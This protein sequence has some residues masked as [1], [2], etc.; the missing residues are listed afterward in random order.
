MTEDSSVTAR[1]PD[2]WHIDKRVSVGHLITTITV[3]VAAIVWALR[4]EG[5]LDVT[6]VNVQN[7]TTAIRQARD[8]RAVQYGEIIRRLER[9]DSKLDGKQSKP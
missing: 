2:H 3:V 4:L 1:P 7:N 8:D 9:L 6:D 5:R